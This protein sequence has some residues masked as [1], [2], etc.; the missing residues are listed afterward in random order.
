MFFFNK[1]LI[2]GWVIGYYIYLKYDMKSGIKKIYIKMKRSV[3][4]FF[5]LYIRVIFYISLLKFELGK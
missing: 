2:V 3:V 5:K 1:Y 4:Y